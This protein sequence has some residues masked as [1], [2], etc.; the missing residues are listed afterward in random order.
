MSTH[1]LVATQVIPRPIDEVFAFF[2]APDNLARLTPAN[3]G[4]EFR[5]ADRT[6]RKGLRIEYRIRPLLGIPLTWHTLIDAYDPPNGFRDVAIRSPYRGWRH[7][8][9]FESV[10]GGTLM[11]DQVDYSLP[12]GFL[13]D[14]I[15]RFVVRGELIR[16]FHHRAQ[17]ISAALRPPEVPP[18]GRVVAVAGGTG[19]VGGAIAA[20]LHRRGDTVV[21]LSHRGEAARGP[22]PDEV[23]IRRADVA[24]PPS[25]GPAL[26]GVDSLVIALAFPN[27]PMEKPSKGRTFEAVDAAGTEH[28]VA[29]ARAAGVKR[30]VYI[31]G[32]GAASDAFLGT[33]GDV[34]DT[35]KDM[36]M[37]LVG[38]T[39]ALVL[40]GR[41]Q[42]RQ[43]RQLPSRW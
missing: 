11:I 37:A 22:L 42:D 16:I 30:I 25:I 20:E 5:T 26:D 18:T 31:S 24:D 38:A 36:F 34:W 14:L 12:F 8:H 40:L 32:A 6:M 35:Q 39:S 41:W 28:L 1:R 7:R 9:S 17:V 13:G 3:L 19:F 4:F 10:Q 15:H 21:A 43:M 27:S 2:S 29:A 33:Q 23:A